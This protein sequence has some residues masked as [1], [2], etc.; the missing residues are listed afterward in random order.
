M[1]RAGSL[2]RPPAAH[3]TSMAMSPSA[4]SSSSS[5][6]SASS[7]AAS[8]SSAFHIAAQGAGRKDREARAVLVVLVVGA[9]VAL[10]LRVVRVGVQRGHLREGHED[11]LQLVHGRGHEAQ[12]RDVGHLVLAVLV[13]VV[14]YPQLAVE[15]R[16]GPN[17][18]IPRHRMQRDEGVVNR[19]PVGAVWAHEPDEPLVGQVQHAL[20]LE[21]LAG[22]EPRPRLRVADLL[23]GVQHRQVTVLAGDLSTGMASAEGRGGR[24]AGLG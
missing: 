24:A 23:P 8:L 18:L 1:T 15:A 13:V 3:F 4:P 10:G 22:K 2:Q 21:V 20:A 16:L 19:I 14:L 12:F 5:S 6:S 17:S 9:A 11:G 7:M